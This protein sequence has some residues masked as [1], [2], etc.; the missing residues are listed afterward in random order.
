M[1][2]ITID[3][4][5]ILAGAGLA[6]GLFP[7]IRLLFRLNINAEAFSAQIQKL[8]LANN[9]DRAIKLCSA[10][11]STPLGQ[12]TRA[13]LKAHQEGVHDSL[14]LKEAFETGTGGTKKVYSKFAW[15]NYLG[16]ALILA[17]AGLVVA[18]GLDP[19]QIEIGLVLGGFVVNYLGIVKPIGIRNLALQV[20]DVL[21]DVLVER[22][23]KS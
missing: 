19:Q 22:A 20:R 15:M 2:A 14:A 13:M 11:S 12:G 7:I 9:V 6:L 18:E 8:V 23:A 16:M 5:I 21:A 1:E 17:A 4:T 3:W 10:V